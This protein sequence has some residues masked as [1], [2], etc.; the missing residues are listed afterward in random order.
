M[1][2]HTLEVTSTKISHPEVFFM[3]SL[4]SEINRLK[5]KDAS[6]RRRA[7]RNLFDFDN[8]VALKGFVDLLNDG[9]QWFRSKAIE[10]HRKWAK[11]PRDIEPLMN[12]NRKI[13]AELN[14]TV[15][16]I[17]LANDL[18]GDDDYLTRYFAAKVLAEDDETSHENLSK[19]S[20]HSVRAL[21]ADFASERIII[22]ELLNDS[23]PLVMKNTI[24]RCL[25][26]GIQVDKLIIRKSLDSKDENL[27]MIASV[28]LIEND[29]DY[30]MDFLN[31]VSPKVKRNIVSKLRETSEEVNDRI[32]SISKK[33]PELI[34][35]WLRG[36]HSKK[37]IDLRWQ[38][39]EDDNVES[40]IRAKLI[41]QMEG[42]L[43]LDVARLEK[44]HS[45]EDDLVKI[46]SMNLSASFNEL[47]GEGE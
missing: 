9:D 19:D 20:H 13:A 31:D 1:I 22:E 36:K 35:R 29:D 45:N 34:Q 16:D 32:I 44:L 21:V 14:Q 17:S 33:Q 18:Y 8:P 38:M 12:N 43:G 23:H 3:P 6:I 7:V 42:K 15:R 2:H 10:A 47:A 30:V 27:R 28:Y 41:E 40:R 46:S 24:E 11:T 26:L 4:D 5:N 37:S 25:E 39:I